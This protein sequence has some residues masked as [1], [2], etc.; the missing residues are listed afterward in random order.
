[1]GNTTLGLDVSSHQDPSSVDW[2]AAARLG[3]RYAVIRLTN[4]V[5][6]DER[7]REHAKRIRGA[8]L[9]LGAYAFWIP[10]RAPERLV[11]AFTAAAE[12]CQ[13]GHPGD[14]IPWLDVESWQGASGY[15]RAAPDW[16]EPAEQTIELLSQS[17]GG[18]ALYC[19]V[20]D[21][22]AMGSPTWIG[23][24]P[25]AAAHYTDKPDP[26]VAGHLRWTFWQ[27]RV[28][29]ILGV[30]ERPID[31]SLC[32]LPLP[33]IQQTDSDEPRDPDPQR[34]DVGWIPVE[35]DRD[36]HS[37]LRNRAVARDTDRGRYG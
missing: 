33:T 20:S 1:M 13:Y 17:F 29:P 26:L 36:E 35:F 21:W 24:Y 27:H 37:R 30:S 12:L 3:Y 10:W 22:A 9:V 5:E 2:V 11:S 19:N 7:A 25:I 8:G 16:S 14:L 15:H 18:C 32:Q 4:G 34:V 28:A 6:L 23:R 31:Q